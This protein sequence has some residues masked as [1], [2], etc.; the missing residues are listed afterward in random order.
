MSLTS[1][2]ANILRISR[3]HTL[4]LIQACSTSRLLATSRALNILR[5][6]FM[7]KKKKSRFRFDILLI[8]SLLILI[9]V[10]CAYVLNT[11][12]IDILENERDTQVVTHDNDY[13]F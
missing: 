2:V 3:S 13:E 11:P 12:V 5:M 8:V 4:L 6:D 1:K 7:A 10:F 9:V